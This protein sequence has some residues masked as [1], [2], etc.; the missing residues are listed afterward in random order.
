V[1]FARNGYAAL[2]SFALTFDQEIH[3]ADG[4]T[5]ALAHHI[6]FADGTWT[7]EQIEE[8]V[9]TVGRKNSGRAG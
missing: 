2:V 9:A 8:L 7:V 5:L 3:L 6:A 1:W 4:K